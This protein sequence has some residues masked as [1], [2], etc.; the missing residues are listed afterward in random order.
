MSKHTKS[1]ARKTFQRRLAKAYIAFLKL[2][3]FDQRRGL[4]N[5]LNDIVQVYRTTGQGCRQRQQ[6]KDYGWDRS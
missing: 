6:A 3:W 4:H 5:H 1:R 2:D